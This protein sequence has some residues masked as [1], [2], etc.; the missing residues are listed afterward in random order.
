VAPRNPPLCHGLSSVNLSQKPRAA[1][2]RA[3]PPLLRMRRQHVLDVGPVVASLVS[4]AEPLRGDRV[5][6]G[7]VVNQGAAEVSLE[8]S[9]GRLSPSN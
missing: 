4:V 5:A 8:S 7:L 9:E 6:V 2:R 1:P 3:A